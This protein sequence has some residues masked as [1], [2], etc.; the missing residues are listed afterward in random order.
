MNTGFK[1]LLWYGC[2]PAPRP[3]PC[4]NGRAKP[5]VES[6]APKVG[7]DQPRSGPGRR[8][9][10]KRERRSRS[11]R[12]FSLGRRSLQRYDLSANNYG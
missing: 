7:A 4:A 12:R 2:R 11:G 3:T 6:L 1:S 10:D 9:G 5:F 8:G